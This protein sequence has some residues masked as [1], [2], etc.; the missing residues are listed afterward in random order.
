[1]SN[2]IS[3]IV[4][5]YNVEKYLDKCIQSILGQTYSNLEVLL[6]DDGST[7]SSGAICDKYAAQDSR[8]RVFHKPNGGSSAARNMGLDNANGEWIAFVDS[9]DWIDA[10]MY[11]QMLN[12]AIEDSVEAVYCGITQEYKHGKNTLYYNC[13]YEDH[14]LMYDCLVPITVEY[15]SMCNKLISRKVFDRHNIRA[16]EG[17]NMWEDVEL[18]L[19]VRYFIASSSVVDRASYHYNLLNASST[20]H[21]AVLSRVE[22]Q[23]E[24]VK[25]MEQFFIQQ[26]DEK[27]YKHF[28]S[29]LK[30]Q[31]KYD[32]FE[33]YPQKWISTFPE[34]K[35]SLFK[36]GNAFTRREI[37]KFLFVSF[38]RDFGVYIIK[39]CR[40]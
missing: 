6:I 36:L 32:L 9:D 14:R 29:A 27:K 35:W 20:T 1:M 24:R 13:K 2:L 15:F 23:V 8:V 37:I 38:F 12:K 19:K 4:P 34:A 30:F 25:Q 10:D 5:V 31:A 39:L 28:I 3:V 21:N 18:A 26:G 22:G 11:E 17:A 33:D 7:D 40:R 16:V